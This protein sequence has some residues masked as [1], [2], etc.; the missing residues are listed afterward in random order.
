MKTPAQWGLLTMNGCDFI[1]TIWPAWNDEDSEFQRRRIMAVR[2]AQVASVV[3]VVV[4]ILASIVAGFE[5]LTVPRLIAVALLGVVYCIWNIVGTRDVVQRL[6]SPPVEDLP[7]F[8]TDR[9]KALFYF[10]I[11]MGLAVLVYGLFQKNSSLGVLWLVL[12]IPVAHS[13]ILLRSTGIA[14]VSS[15]TI[16]IFATFFVYCRGWSQLA[17]ALLAFI[18]AV[19]FTLV[20]TLLAASSERSRGEV[21]V[22]ACKLSAANQKLREYA[23]QAEELAATRERNRLAR[24]IHDTLG[25]YLTVVNVQIEV[26]RMMVQRDPSKALDALNKAQTLTQEGLLDIRRSVSALRTSPLDNKDLV[27]ALR[28]LIN[29][30]SGCGVK[31]EFNVIDTPK[32]LSPAIKLTLYRVAQEGF[33]NI[34]KH[35]KATRAC[36]TLDFSTADKV[37]LSLIDNGIGCLTVQSG[38]FGL[39]GLRER[40]HLS[41]GNLEIITKPSKGFHLQVDLPI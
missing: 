17:S 22:M 18:F 13:V 12:L 35:S 31:T 27:D 1:S 38:G 4:A 26:A 19:F 6:F 14:V 25:H 41:S 16:L 30:A 10:G 9:M 2:S 28:E 29:N 36:L 39:S 40:A 34:Q 24:E 33:T 15:V 20:F 23:V 32:S 37:R 5:K 21:E 7:S 11:Q 3:L 8:Q